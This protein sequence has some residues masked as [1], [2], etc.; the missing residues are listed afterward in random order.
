VLCLVS[1]SLLS[2][3]SYKLWLT[4][5]DAEPAPEL[6]RSDS[7]SDVDL[8]TPKVPLL[9]QLM[10]VS[11]DVEPIYLSGPLTRPKPTIITQNLHSL[12]LQKVAV[13]D[14][15]SS[16]DNTL[17]EHGSDLEAMTS[18]F[19]S[20]TS[21]DI[22]ESQLSPAQLLSVLPPLEV[23][24]SNSPNAIRPS[25]EQEGT[26]PR[27]RSVRFNSRVR[28]TSGI[29]RYPKRDSQASQHTIIATQPPP[30][31]PA[32]L[33]STRHS[34][35]NSG[36]ST[37][38]PLSS[39]ASSIS[40]PLRSAGDDSPNTSRWGPLGQR[41]SWMASRYGF[42]R[43]QQ[44]NHGRRRAGGIAGY[45]EVNGHTS[46]TERT[47]LIGAFMRTAYDEG[48]PSYQHRRAPSSHSQAHEDD[49]YDSS[50]YER[51]HSPSTSDLSNSKDV[52]EIFGPLPG[53]LFNRHVRSFIPSST[54]LGF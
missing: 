50:E 20:D 27:K 52:D 53:R 6:T 21:T 39:A 14:S 5:Y 26:L 3:G 10:D 54:L 23:D 17:A 38:S 33:Y 2:S 16:S 37:G 48:T 28:I 32:L 9:G 51:L 1:P 22:S 40:A 30:S 36:S 41:V 29:H 15:E 43:Q 31:D 45:V 18:S 8:E 13:V 19:N 7:E 46:T 11:T 25:G 49:N 4:W 42:G 35:A 24:H 44:H 47:P 12:K 34:R